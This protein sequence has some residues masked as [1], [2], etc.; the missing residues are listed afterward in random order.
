MKKNLFFLVFLLSNF[1]YGQTLPLVVDNSVFFPPARTQQNI[2]DCSYFSLIYYLKS[3]EWNKH[4]NRDP[5][6][7]ENQFSHSFAWNQNIDPTTQMSDAYGAFYFM[8]SQG[9]A[10]VADF[11]L[12]ETSIDVKPSLEL[13]KKALAYKS[14]RLF[15]VNFINHPT[16]DDV[17][18]KLIALKDSLARGKCFS[19]DFRVFDSA[20][21]LSDN[22]NVYSCYPGT[23]I[24]SMRQSHAA[25]VIGY[26]DTIKTATGRG[27]FEILDSNTEK[28]THGIFYFDYNWF[29]LGIFPNNCNFIEEDFSSQA[30]KV[31][32]NLSLSGALTGL[33]IANRNN[34]FVDT[35]LDNPFYEMYPVKKIDF[36]NYFNYLYNR[37]QVQVSTINKSRTKMRNNLIYFPFNSVDGN[38]ELITDLSSINDLKSLSVIVYDPIS[39]SYI[40][41]NDEVLYSYQR[42][43]TCRV[44]SASINLLTAGKNIVAKVIDLPDTT[45]VFNDF[46]GF[47]VAGHFGITN[48]HVKSC[49]SVL[50]RKL[51]TFTIEENPAPVFINPPSSLQ[52]YTNKSLSYQFEASDANGSQIT[53]KILNPLSGVSISSSGLMNL[54]LAHVGTYKFT[55]VASNSLASTNKAVSVIVDLD[56]A[57]D[58]IPVGVASLNIFPNPL[59]NSATVEF[60]LPKE[61]IAR[62]EVFNSIGQSVGT[63]TNKTYDA[64]KQTIDYD[65]SELRSGVYIFRFISGSFTKSLKVVKQ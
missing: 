47:L 40:G 19:L 25:A 5:K 4:F 57:T 60:T 29:Y 55:V 51:I 37:N 6:L 27:A 1:I 45:F 14:K 38:Y 15:N 63:V 30:P 56:T 31:V 41:Q 26:N 53:Y 33:D 61:G 7:A 42:E 16:R 8:K 46:Y 44:N 32:M 48:G 35:L 9:C 12:T 11:P 10:T 34:C 58:D 21:K 13:R 3:Y 28:L 22:H 36:D 64:G 43:A 50:K 2:P 62:I 39:A 59:V 49:T 17:A 24:D 54:K 65:A 20:M 23:S 52:A 18:R